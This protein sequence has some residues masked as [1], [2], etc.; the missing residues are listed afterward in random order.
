MH[1]T[2]KVARCVSVGVQQKWA[3]SIE[4][5]HAKKQANIS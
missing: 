3:F 1:L 2:P 5:L 4:N